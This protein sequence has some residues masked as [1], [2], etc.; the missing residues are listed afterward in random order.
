MII[1]IALSYYV[2]L[3][4]DYRHIIISIIVLYYYGMLSY[5]IV[6]YAIS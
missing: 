1:M 2:T 3:S 4:Y 6:C 5:I